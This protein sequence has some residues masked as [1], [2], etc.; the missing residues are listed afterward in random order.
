VKRRR[1]RTEG[2]KI[3]AS[4]EASGEAAAVFARRRGINQRT[5]SWWRSR[6]RRDGAVSQ[7]ATT[8]VEVESPVPARAPRAPRV[9][10]YVGAVSVEFNDE[11][12][13]AA[14]IAELAGRC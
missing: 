3:C 5:F 9:V 11:T 13:L 2:I 10:A 12:P 8:F 14:W 6:L 1:S 7:V 4:F